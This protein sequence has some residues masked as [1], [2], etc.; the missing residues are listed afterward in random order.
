MS[1]YIPL[2]LSVV[3]TNAISQ[4]LLKRGMNDIGKFEFPGDRCLACS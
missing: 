1:R 4:L 3:L 2:I